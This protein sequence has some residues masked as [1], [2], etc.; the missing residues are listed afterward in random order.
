MST[1]PS[2]PWTS[3]VWYE[4]ALK[5][6]RH[7]FWLSWRS[8][9]HGQADVSEEIDCCLLADVFVFIYTYQKI[10]RLYAIQ[11]SCFQSFWKNIIGSETY[12]YIYIRKVRFQ[13]NPHPSLLFV[14]RIAYFINIKWQQNLNILF[15][16]IM[17]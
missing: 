13:I 6:N 4:N 1:C 17:K 9:L 10:A 11:F 2:V 15:W 16:Q 7:K 8:S 3:W 5:V 12:T 14:F